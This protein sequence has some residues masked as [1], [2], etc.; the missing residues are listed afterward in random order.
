MF[1]TLIIGLEALLNHRW[2][3]PSFGV[4]EP[5]DLVWTLRICISSKSLSGAAAAGLGP[6]GRQ[7]LIQGTF[8]GGLAF[9][10]SPNMFP[11]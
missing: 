6:S 11:L 10:F 8:W 3:G 1:I 7:S 4:S 5:V 9:I 2:L